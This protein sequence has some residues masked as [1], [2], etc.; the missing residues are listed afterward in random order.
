[1]EPRSRHP[2]TAIRSSTAYALMKDRFMRES[3]AA[4]SQRQDAIRQL[5]PTTLMAKAASSSSWS[6]IYQ[7]NLIG[8][9][10]PEGQ[11]NY[12]RLLNAQTQYTSHS[13]V[14]KRDAGKSLMSQIEGN[15]A[16][17]NRDFISFLESQFTSGEALSW[18]LPELSGIQGKPVSQGV[19]TPLFC[20]HTACQVAHLTC[21]TTAP[22]PSPMKQSIRT[23]R[24]SKRGSIK[25]SR[26]I[27]GRDL[28]QLAARRA[29][30]P[31][32]WKAC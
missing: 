25:V 27:I 4:S 18:F 19:A 32:V 17:S 28:F 26:S 30:L 15:K 2:A 21:T 16:R 22:S 8:G 6:E 13:H 23:P 5:P 3:H 10:I 20:A 24:T 9:D 12:W 1:M 14:S 29:G 11:G 7:Y 31:R